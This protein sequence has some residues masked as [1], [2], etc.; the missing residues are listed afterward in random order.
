MRLSELQE[1]EVINCRDGKRVGCVTDIEFNEK[2]GDIEA[3]ILQTNDKFFG[4]F[5]GSEMV[6]PWDKI[7]VIGKDVVIIETKFADK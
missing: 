5:G 4:I 7:K 2:C 1:K 6:V 3:L